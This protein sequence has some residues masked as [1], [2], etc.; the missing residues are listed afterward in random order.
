M[1]QTQASS[2]S[3]Y[4][5]SDLQISKKIAF[6][7]SPSAIKIKRFLQEVVGEKVTVPNSWYGLTTNFGVT[8]AEEAKRIERDG[9]EVMHPFSNS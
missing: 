5:R 9:F 2:T 1:C 6:R 7:L 4:Q 8:L 3:Q